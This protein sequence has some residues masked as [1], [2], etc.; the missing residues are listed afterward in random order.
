M[1]RRLE[2]LTVRVQREGDMVLDIDVDVGRRGIAISRERLSRQAAVTLSFPSSFFLSSFSFVFVRFLSLISIG[3]T[4]TRWYHP[5][6]IIWCHD[7]DISLY[8]LFS[9]LSLFSFALCPPHSPKYALLLAVFSDYQNK[10]LSPNDSTQSIKSPTIY[11]FVI[12]AQDDLVQ[13]SY[14]VCGFCLRPS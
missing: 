10:F 4:S 7:I 12:P 8:S 2:R 1:P 11:A 6:D 3:E 9:L 5:S 14:T 13:N